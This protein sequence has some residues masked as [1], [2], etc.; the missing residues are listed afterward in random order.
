VRKQSKAILSISIVTCND[1]RIAMRR[2]RNK[3]AINTQPLYK[4]HRVI[5]KAGTLLLLP[6]AALAAGPWP[7]LVALN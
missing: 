1:K 6:S 7:L 4:Y 2:R 5:V 3:G